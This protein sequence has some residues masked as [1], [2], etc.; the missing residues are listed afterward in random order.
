MT[1]SKHII[2][3]IQWWIANISFN[4]KRI[5]HGTP[6]LILFSDASKKG[7]GAYNETENIRTGGK[8]SLTE[9]VSHINIL[10][11]KACQLCLHTICKNKDNTH[12][13]IYMDNTTSCTYINKFGG[14][15]S[16]SDTIAREIWFWCMERPIY[17]SA[18]HVPGKDNCEADAESRTEND[19]TE[20]SLNANIF[21]TIHETFPG[22][23]VDLFASRLNNKLPKYVVSTFQLA[24]SDLTEN[25]SGQGVGTFDTTSVA[26]TKLVAKSSPSGSRSMLQATKHKTNSTSSAQTRTTTPNEKT[27]T[28]MFSI[29]QRSLKN[30]GVPKQARELILKS[31]RSSTKQQYNGYISK[32]FKFC[33][34]QINP[35]K[36]SINE[37]LKFLSNLYTVQVSGHS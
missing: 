18:A 11:P 32:W 33:G 27:E 3:T 37:I 9:Q 13:R 2:P 21:N 24:T 31:W 7:W 30:T 12:V 8:W 1:I 36:P 16:E 10:E 5:S 17:L 22:L 26:Y 19:D 6:E 29:I 15:T 25:R 23:T 34:Q 28:G 4:Y 20:W 14:C 35:I